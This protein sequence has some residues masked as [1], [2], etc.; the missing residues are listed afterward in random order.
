MLGVVAWNSKAIHMEVEKQMFD[1]KRFD[2]SCWN[3][4]TKS[5]LW[6]LDPVWSFH[7]VLW[8]LT[9]KESAK[10]GDIDQ[11]NPL[12]KEM[13]TH[14]SI[15]AWKNPM[16]RGAWRATIKEVAKELDTT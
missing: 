5:R 3:K 8:W 16:D 13:T 12:K 15:L 14:S 10:A 11:E 4:G 9:G 7:G 6:S 2:V 1:E